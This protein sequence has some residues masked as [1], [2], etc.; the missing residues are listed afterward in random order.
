MRVTVKGW[1]AGAVSCAL[2]AAAVPAAAQQKA[3]KGT[4]PPATAPQPA[5]GVA[6]ALAV[7]TAAQIA[8]TGAT[9]IKAALALVPALVVSETG[10]PGGVALVSLRGSTSQ[11][12][13]VLLDGRRLANAGN[14]SFN[15]NDVPVPVERVE[16]IVVLPGSASL[17]Y[18]ADAIGGVVNI[19]TRAPGVKPGFDAGYGAGADGEQRIS[20][21]LQYGVGSLGLRLDGQLHSGD[22]ER[23]NA[24]YDIEQF[25]GAMSLPAAPWGVDLRYS[26]FGRTAGAP[27][28]VDAPTPSAR[29]SDDRRLFRADFSYLAA[30]S[31]WSVRSGVFSDEQTQRLADP[32]PPET[33]IRHD[34]TSR[35]A[36]AQWTFATGQGEV[37]TVGGEWV[38]DELETEGGPGRDAER[39]ALYAEDQWRSGGLSAVGAIRRDEHSVY[40]S[41]TNPAVTVA[42]EAG[43]WKV[44]GAWAKGYRPPSFD[45]RFADDRFVKGDPDLRPETS[46]SYEGG[47]QFGSGAGR[48][49]A[50]TFRREVED[51]IVWTDGI[52]GGAHRPVN[53]ADAV[54]TGWEAEVIYTPT[55]GIAMP[56]G[57]QVLNTEDGE[58]GALVPGSVTSLWRAAVQAT[59]GAFT[60]SLEYQFTEREGTAPGGG[61]TSASVL[62][63]ALAWN[64]TF[65][66]FPVRI[67]VRAENL[68]DESYESVE[69]YPQRGRSYFVEARVGM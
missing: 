40:G 34:T 30:E 6:G 39:W 11:Q 8:A 13:L 5:S 36:D 1:M 69:G 35:G 58:T 28:A 48:A 16:R 67:S 18:G 20:G 54:V 29:R 17:L 50:S 68:Q 43:G 2:L 59:G 26:S 64:H 53:V 46:E 51:L 55:A 15:L 19:V 38:T 52:A 41:H 25:S 66:S 7:I 27:G 21:G 3:G 22:G 65:G 37:Y 9:D 63:M 44:W 24:D 47:L 62:N 57:Y 10:G 60:S 61:T 49:R 56:I 45:E 14:A 31:G 23:D 32:D 42:W 33:A 4:P 12:V